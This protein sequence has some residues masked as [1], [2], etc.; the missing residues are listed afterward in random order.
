MIH[1]AQN[2]VQK[3]WASPSY[4]VI[5]RTIAQAHVTLPQFRTQ[6]TA[7]AGCKMV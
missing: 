1:T 4:T 6:T 5:T 2:N 7:D 3:Q